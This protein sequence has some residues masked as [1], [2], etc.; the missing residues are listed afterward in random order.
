MSISPR[1]RAQGES[2][3]WHK[4]SHGF[5]QAPRG[6]YPES[7]RWDLRISPKTNIFGKS[8]RKTQNR[9]PKAGFIGLFTYIIYIYIYYNYY[10]NYMTGDPCT[11]AATQFTM[12]LISGVPS[13]TRWEVAMGRKSGEG[14]EPHVWPVLSIRGDDQGRTLLAAGIRTG[15]EVIWLVLH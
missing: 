14:F 2:A 7:S 8:L 13:G 1:C 4:P 5:A 10:N 11:V 3:R 9:P 12:T 15:I 6:P